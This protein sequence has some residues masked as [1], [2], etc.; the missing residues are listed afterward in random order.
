[1][2]AI[3]ALT[4]RAS[5]PRL[6]APGPDAEAVQTILRSALR[7]PDH[8]MLRPWR[9]LT[10]EGDARA[11]FGDVL[12][13]ALAARIPGTPAAAVENERGKPLRAPLIIVAAA[14]TDPQHPKIPEVEQVASAAAAAQNI[15]LAAHA[16]GFGCFWRTGQPAYD[17]SVKEALG[18][19]PTDH[20]V[21]F[22]YIGTPTE[23]APD[24][25]RRPVVEDF[26]EAWPP[27]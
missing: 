19:A 21:G 26:L 13:R 3:E 11:R 18:L 22:M 6:G 2:D 7:A 8:G 14:R 16:L 20:I 5:L 10:I 24:K 12:A 17:P 27:A 15:S 25:G 23:S 1:M 9:F 4:T